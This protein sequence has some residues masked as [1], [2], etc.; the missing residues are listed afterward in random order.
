MFVVDIFC[1]VEGYFWILVWWLCFFIFG[2]VV[3]VIDYF[4]FIY[5]IVWIGIGIGIGE[6]VYWIIVFLNLYFKF[7]FI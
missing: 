2:D 1:V 7:D 3:V 4:F 5:V 6:F